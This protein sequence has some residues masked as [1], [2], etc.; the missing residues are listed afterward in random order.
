M[1]K[2]IT[3]LFS[4]QKYILIVDREMLF[5]TCYIGDLGNHKIRNDKLGTLNLIPA[6]HLDITSSDQ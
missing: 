6:H 5:Y 1:Q 3:S 4:L 2:N